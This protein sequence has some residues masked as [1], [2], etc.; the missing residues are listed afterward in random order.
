MYMRL[1]NALS[2][3]LRLS[4]LRSALQEQRRRRKEKGPECRELPGTADPGSVTACLQPVPL[5]SGSSPTRPSG[6]SSKTTDLRW[7]LM[8]IL[9][10]TQVQAQNL[11]PIPVM[12]SLALVLGDT[13]PSPLAPFCL[14]LPLLSMSPATA[15]GHTP[16]LPYH[17]MVCLLASGLPFP[18]LFH[19]SGAGLTFLKSGAPFCSLPGTILSVHQGYG[20]SLGLTRATWQKM[21][22]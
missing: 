10:C 15:L 14:I 6:I 7:V 3:Q 16:A 21:P 11:G 12:N 8:P 1:L 5:I 22:L 18:T 13:P 4:G 19:P 9:L 20:L 17:T 2:S